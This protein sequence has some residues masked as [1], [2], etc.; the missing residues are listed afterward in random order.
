MRDT[1]NEYYV[2]GKDGYYTVSGWLIVLLLIFSGGT[3]ANL[4]VSRSYMWSDP[5]GEVFQQL[6]G[7]C[8]YSYPDNQPF[9]IP[10][11][12]VVDN[13]AP[14]GTIL[15]SWSYADF[16]TSFMFSCTG[17]GIESSK[18]DILNT[19]TSIS[20]T[21]SALAGLGFLLSG[22]GSGIL[23]TSV[24]G[25][26]IRFYVRSDSSG[27]GA[28]GSSPAYI[29]MQG[30]GNSGTQYAASGVE[31][32][33]VGPTLGAAALIINM[34]QSRAGDTNTLWSIPTK[35]IS[36][37]IRA[38]LVKTG[39]VTAYGPLSVG[40]L[41]SWVPPSPTNINTTPSSNFLTG[42]GV[43]LVRPTCKLSS[44]RSTDY[45][46]GMGEWN[47]DTFAGVPVYGPEVPVRLELECNG[48]A[49]NVR[50]RFEDSGASHLPVNN[51]SLY[52]NASGNKIDGLEI[53]LLHNGIHI[54]VNGD[55]VD[56]GS[57]GTGNNDSFTWM[58]LQARYVQ[59]SIIT[60]SG[61]SFSGQIR[62]VVNIFMVYD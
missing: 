36:L 50:M 23:D 42:T 30:F 35:S 28:D 11:S 57:Y 8:V 21:P 19:E 4:N 51:I 38:E 62:G 15:M 7:N 12:V 31:Y 3:S 49:D 18:P 48:M 34:L 24:E 10:R 53:E 55:A 54:D 60:R 26:G 5:S 9:S 27:L 25:I 41:F 59:R 2:R 47:A 20:V 44:Q 46:I 13:S 33:L 58:E 17:S 56:L 37:S 6:A 43:M 61:D 40:N 29:R 22:S 14:V 52:D 1:R 39:Y 45:T 32:P 16:N